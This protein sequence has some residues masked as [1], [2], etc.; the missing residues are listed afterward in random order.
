MQTITRKEPSGTGHLWRLMV[1]AKDPDAYISM[2]KANAA[3]FEAIGS[4]M[5]GACVTKTGADYPG[6]MFIWNAFDSLEQAMASTDK[7]D[8]MKATA[9]L[10]AIREVQYNV[11]F[12]PL[13][14]FNLQPNSERLWRLEI[15]PENLSPFVNKITAAGRCTPNSGT[16]GKPRC[17]ST[18][19]GW[20]T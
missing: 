12:K 20:R 18:Y 7:Y 10:T 5:A 19:R 3:P 2:L 9:E 15:S 8:P 13:K 1:K 6:Q 17:F 11:M 4:S 14:P 16:Q